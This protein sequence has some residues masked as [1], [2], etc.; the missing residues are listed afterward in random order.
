M[1]GQVGHPRHSIG[2]LCTRG[3]A[4][5]W[6]ATG[7]GPGGSFPRLGEEEMKNLVRASCSV[8]G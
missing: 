2:G 4:Y 7:L 3:G 8:P 5:I 1:G 6:R